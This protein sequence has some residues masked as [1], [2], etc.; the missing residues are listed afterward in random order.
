MRDA[1]FSLLDSVDFTMKP[2]YVY[3]E[4]S[5]S[6]RPAVS[7]FDD[8]LGYYPE[9]EYVSRGPGYDPAVYIWCTKQ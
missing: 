8:S 7:M 3:E 2:T 5:F 9:A 1:P 4:T 6:G